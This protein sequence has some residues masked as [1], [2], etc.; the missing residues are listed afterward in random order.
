MTEI[1]LSHPDANVDC[2]MGKNIDTK[3]L[4]SCMTLF[5]IVSDP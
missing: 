3:K 5:S 2:L 1:I 4:Q